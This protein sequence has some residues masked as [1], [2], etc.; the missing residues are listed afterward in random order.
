MDVYL[1]GHRVSV[2]SGFVSA[3]FDFYEKL[4][5]FVSFAD[6]MDY[7]YDSFEN[8]LPYDRLGCALLSVDGVVSRWSRSNA[9]QHFL[10]K[11]FYAPLEGSSLQTILTTHK[12]RIINDLGKHYNE[13]RKSQATR[14]ILKEGFQSNL[15]CP[16]FNKGEPVGFLFFSSFDT[17]VYRDAHAQLFQVVSNGVAAAIERSLVHDELILANSKLENLAYV[18]SLTSLWN[19]RY[20]FDKVDSLENLSARTGVGTSSLF[21][22]F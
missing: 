3:V 4:N 8:I 11:G 22:V 12:P 2:S 6:T 9:P 7:I 20:L 21:H 1:S 14:L 5:N 18:D 10:N 15:T 13:V 17:G 16:L 19:R